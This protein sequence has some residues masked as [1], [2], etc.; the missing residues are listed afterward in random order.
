M[1]HSPW[2]GGKVAV[3][4]KSDTC[5]Y[6]IEQF[7][8]ANDQAS[9]DIGNILLE[10]HSETCPDELKANVAQATTDVD[11]IKKDLQ[12]TNES[13]TELGALLVASSAESTALST[14]I[15]EV[16]AKK[17]SINAQ[18]VKYDDLLDSCKGSED[19]GTKQWIR[20]A[21]QMSIDLRRQLEGLNESLVTL[22]TL[23]QQLKDTET[24]ANKG[25]ADCLEPLEE[26]S[27]GKKHSIQECLT[28]IDKRKE[29]TS[30]IKGI[31][32]GIYE[33]A[34][35][36]FKS[37]F[38]AIKTISSTIANQFTSADALLKDSEVLLETCPLKPNPGPAP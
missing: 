38:E 5:G 28:E 31:V 6:N 30:Q 2:E 7:K 9:L 32:T 33:S 17:A 27:S 29:S 4:L 23:Q 11:Q 22:N 8:R 13:L 3:E 25:L 16:E 18:L 24:T 12:A 10:I 15:K 37:I 14:H 19:E 35:Q 26:D 34:A 20:R 1:P 36:S 21:T